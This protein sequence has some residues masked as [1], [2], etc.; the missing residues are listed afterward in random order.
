M[1]TV[2]AALRPAWGRSDN[3]ARRRVLGHMSK[4]GE[5]GVDPA[6]RASS[7]TKKKEEPTT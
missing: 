6:C 2:A 4:A 1:Q 7:L 5:L 3:R